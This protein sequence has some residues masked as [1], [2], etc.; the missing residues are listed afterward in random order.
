MKLSEAF[1]SK[2]IA[3]G[4]LGDADAPVT[5][6]A[7]KLESMGE[8]A[9]AKDKLILSFHEMPKSMICNKTNA[10]TI[11]KIHGDDTDDWIGKRISL[12]ATEVEYAGETMLGIRV[13]LRAP[14]GAGTA[15][16]RATTAAPGG[17]LKAAKLKAWEE[18]ARREGG[19]GMTVV[20]KLKSAVQAY[21]GKGI[22]ELTSDEWNVLRINNFEKPLEQQ[23][24]EIFG[25]EQ[26]FA[27]DDIP[28]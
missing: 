6:K 26:V 18:F 27:A 3:A 11:A 16:A 8:G 1:P 12:Y 14:G 7:V 15:P 9:E 25:G 4:D 24:A 28:I 23:A 17:D 22:D 13:R 21:Y 20:T 2:H 10:G 19:T 5:I